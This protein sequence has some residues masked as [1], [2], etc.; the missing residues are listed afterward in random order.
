MVRVAQVCRLD[1]SRMRDEVLGK[2]Y[3]LMHDFCTMLTLRQ[4]VCLPRWI[5]EA[6]A[7]ALPE[8]RRFAEG[9][10]RDYDAVRGAL[11]RIQSRPD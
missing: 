1:P 5:E 2:A 8:L 9:L 6:K 7:S 10:L 4:M 3:E 11:F